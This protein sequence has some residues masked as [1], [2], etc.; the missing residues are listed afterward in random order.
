MIGG[1]GLLEELSET[2]ELR[3]VGRLISPA[4]LRVED[5]GGDIGAGL[6]HGQV[7]DGGG[8]VLDAASQFTR[9]DCIDNGTR[10]AKGN[11]LP[12]TISATNPASVHEP[13]IHIVV[14]DLV[15]EHLGVLCG[16][17]DEE[18]L[19][20]AG[21]EGGGGLAYALLSASNLGGV[22]AD[23][24]VHG[25]SSRQLANR[26]EDTKGIAGQKDNVLRVPGN[27]RDTGVGDVLDGI[28]TTRVLRHRAIGVIHSTAHMVNDDILEDTSETDGVKDFWFALAGE[29]NALCVAAAFN[30]EDAVV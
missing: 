4:A 14:M 2:T 3:L 25:L 16:M 26:R 1:E 21:R 12:D 24:V 5:I 28:G 15:S 19:P 10:V 7:E 29:V 8:L 11:A 27:T 22:S 23:K 30:V 18:G 6:G 9:V 13:D 20:E 17:P